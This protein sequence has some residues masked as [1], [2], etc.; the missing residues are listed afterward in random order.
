[1]TRPGW[2]VLALVALACNGS[3]GG[4]DTPPAV[5]SPPVQAI[6]T[7]SADEP[8]PLT[9]ASMAAVTVRQASQAPVLDSASSSN[10][11]EDERESRMARF[12]KMTFKQG[13]AAA[14]ESVAAGKL[15]YYQTA[16]ITRNLSQRAT[17]RFYAILKEKEVTLYGST[18][19][20]QR[21]SDEYQ[22]GHNSVMGVA[23]R[24]RH[25]RNFL[26]RVR[27]RAQRAGRKRR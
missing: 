19:C 1:M 14:R 17:E 16:W 11:P 26:R 7:T 15:S 10:P 6:T 13:K 5:S 18:G 9:S 3:R 20:T 8:A 23:I 24:T 12:S 21:G 4:G 25:G 2:G 27:R 22:R